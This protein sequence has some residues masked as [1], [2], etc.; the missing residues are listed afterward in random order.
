MQR[1]HPPNGRTCE[2]YF[3]GDLSLSPSVY[4]SSDMRSNAN[5][6]ESKLHGHLLMV[7]RGVGHTPIASRA[8]SIAL[9]TAIALL[10]RM[11]HRNNVYSSHHVC[12][13]LM[14]LLEAC[15]AALMAA[16]QT[17]A[18]VDQLAAVVTLVH[19]VWPTAVV[20]HVGNCRAYH[21]RSGYVDQITSDHTMANRLV[22][23]GALSSRRA[24]E[25][26]LRNVV[27]NVVGT[28]TDHFAPEIA[29]VHLNVGDALVLCTDGVAAAAN[30]EDIKQSL[31]STDSAK[32]ACQQLLS[33]ADRR[34]MNEDATVIVARFPTTESNRS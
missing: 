7:V 9:D 29:E 4:Q 17:D 18:R 28:H 13:D 11:V 22:S 33:N 14:H 32:Q 5:P 10:P 34:A 26:R 31:Q 15:R 6:I 21:Y 12:D 19:I 24:L 8:S 27:W 1:T 20:A 25:S 30:H 2:H 23:A 16:I 3:I